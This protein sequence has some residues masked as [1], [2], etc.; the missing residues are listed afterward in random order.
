MVAKILLLHIFP[1]S[2]YQYHHTDRWSFSQSYCDIIYLVNCS[3]LGTVQIM[4]IA[5]MEPT[6][7]DPG[8]YPDPVVHE[9][10][11]LILA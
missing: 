7:A 11:Q 5:A 10:I 9:S 2:Y 4:T 6:Q 8:K 1:G 3:F